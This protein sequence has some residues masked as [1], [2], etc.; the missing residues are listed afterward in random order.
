[1]SVC[2]AC[3]AHNPEGFRFC[4]ECGAQLG[5][6][7]CANCGEPYQPGQR[8][9][10]RCGE[11]LGP[12][13][14]AAQVNIPRQERK[15]ATVLF[16]DVVGFTSLA[17]RND[18]E[19]VARMVDAAFRELASVVTA[20]GGTIDKYMGDSLMAV[21][22]VPTAHDDDAERAVAAA[23]AMRKLGGDLV[24]SI[25]IN[26]GEVMATA[27][28][29]E[30]DMTVI[31]D[32]VNVAARLEKAAGP[33]EVL[34]G[35]LT[36]ELVGWRGVFRP[37]QPVILKGKREP[38]DVFEAVGLRSVGS[39]PAVD[40]LP[41]VGRTDEMA[42]LGALWQRVLKDGQLQ[43]LVLCGEPGSGKTRLV[44]EL[45]NLAAVDGSVVRATYPGYGPLGGVK[46]VAEVLRQIGLSDDDEVRVRVRSLAGETD[47]A[48]K[49]M[50]PMAL[51]KEQLWG[52]ARLLED[53]GAER[54]MLI[55]LD[56]THR[57]SETVLTLLD[58]LTRRLLDVPMLMVLVG[59][60]DPGS[61]LSHFQAATTL[62]LGPLGR[63]DAA[64]LTEVL[65]CDKPLS[66]EAT[67]FLVDRAGGNPLYM[68]ELVRV[69]RA[70]GSLIDSGE[71]YSL[72]PAAGLP[73]S[74]HAVLSARLDSLGS[75][76]KVI[77]QHVSV[78]GGG[79]T[80]DLVLRM[81]E[82]AAGR[83]AATALL[84]LVDAG[85]LRRT[86]EGGVEPVDPLLAEVAYETLPRNV[87]GD[88]H[89]Q[90]ATLVARTE[91][92]ARH[93]ER[94][95]VFLSGDL[96]L[97]REASDLLAD[98]G[99]E[100]I[101]D[102]RYPEAQRL[103]ERAVA[104]GCRRPSVLLRLADLQSMGGDI[105]VVQ[106]TLDLI[107]DDPDDP[108]VAVER[109]HASARTRLFN[110]PATARP[111]LEQVAH[112]W[113]E[114]DQPLCEAWAWGNA[115]VA[116]FNLNRGAEATADLEKALDMFERLGDR[117]GAV[118][119]SSFLCLVHPSD[120]RVPGWLAD[121]LAFADET[122]ER[123][124]QVGALGLL[125]WNHFV[126]SMFGGPDHTAETEGFARRLTE[127][128]EQIGADEMELQG[129]SLLAISYRWTGRLDAAAG[130]QALLARIL[131]RSTRRSSWIAW[132][133]GF[134][135]EVA[136]GSATAAPPFPPLD[137]T[138]AVTGMAGLVLRAEL[139]F[140]GRID[141]ARH[142]ME[143]LSGE[144]G[145]VSE[146]TGVIDALTFVLSGQFDAGRLAAERAARAGRT[147]DAQPIQTIARAL[148]AETTGD[149]DLL[150]LYPS[151]PTSIADAV[152]L[153][154][155]ARAG[156]RDAAT[157]LERIATSLAL[158]GLLT[159]VYDRQ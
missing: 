156:T 142:R 82:T 15:L 117:N 145:T 55:A 74:L 148:L 111:L 104:L 100:Y 135:V 19:V 139:L 80:Q 61:W 4:G 70:T 17:E 42:Y 45:A 113:H 99:E 131:D 24:F 95:A 39:T 154:A 75:V 97:S 126:R 8:F 53:K 25:G 13:D 141:E 11:A 151:T 20:H 132:A 44:S 108:G 21:F 88:L 127:T 119:T 84:S 2:A 114:L 138:D 149:A 60:N 107:E 1:V 118:N 27:I 89:R 30:E 6:A 9:C 128:A 63:S 12:G 73:A 16:A 115:G 23:L 40:D 130:Q 136:G 112:R 87:R 7:A 159:G 133:S 153:R 79:A 5:G 93:I 134:V 106:A 65:V 47:E 37:R 96:E 86:S 28:G 122:G 10:G 147:L 67:E 68:R 121:S 94:A 78:L 81:S 18:H 3:G 152:V 76:P 22:G 125:T 116:S 83:E 155:H 103:L 38:V 91:D 92:R 150:P 129:R 48:L 98:I 144:L 52:L 105:S 29:T 36:A 59:R 64:A 56:D 43:L 33:G 143:A 158:P 90:A 32:T 123:D 54:P 41:L 14:A 101:H 157:A 146:A 31:G 109:D 69:A 34:C 50:D 26:S 62:R 71:Q 51:Q 120:P 72:G 102:A 66:S 46:V 110:D 35:P 85:L 49:A 137:V 77:F 124:K 58:E 57:S 140:S